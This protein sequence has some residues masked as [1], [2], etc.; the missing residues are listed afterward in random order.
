MRQP[1]KYVGG[2]IGCVSYN[3]RSVKM[4]ELIKSKMPEMSKGQKKI[5]E[6]ILTNYEKAAFMTAAELGREVGVS[7]ST[8]VRY[9]ALLGYKGYPE[10]QKE[11]EKMVQRK[12][13]AIER[14]NIDNPDIS[15]KDILNSVIMSDI[16]K[17]KLSLELIDVNIFNEA[18]ESILNA[19]TIYI[20]GLRNCLPLAQMLGFNLNMMFDNVKVIT[21][22]SSS[23][24]FEQLMR[25]SDKD[26]I[27]GISFPRYSMRTL[28]AIEF[29]NDRNAEVIAITD[30]INSPMNLYSS[31]NLFARSELTSVMDSLTAP[32]SLINALI[33]ALTIKNQDKVINTLDTL[34]NIWNDYQVYGSDEINIF[35]DTTKVGMEELSDE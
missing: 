26:V 13:H 29:A 20:V 6:F 22:T 34:E 5:S 12:L 33:V 11:V 30:S 4:D 10:M 9:A 17:L 15:R 8:V 1:L 3:W 21:T 7:E 32:V 35:D 27:I 2:H 16:E 25:I 31:C 24:I 23:E 18:V 14:V 28:K 19:E